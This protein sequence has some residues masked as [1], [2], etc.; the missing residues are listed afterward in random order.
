MQVEFSALSLHGEEIEIASC[1]LHW[2]HEHEKRAK[3]EKE[4]WKNKERGRAKDGRGV[5]RGGTDD[6]LQ[7]DVSNAEPD[8]LLDLLSIIQHYQT[9]WDV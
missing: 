6:V 7:M 9:V 3:A 4:K 8:N 1:E 2:V 5:L